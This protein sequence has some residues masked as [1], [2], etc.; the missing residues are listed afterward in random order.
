MDPEDDAAAVPDDRPAVPEITRRRLTPYLTGDRGY[1][2]SWLPTLLVV[3]VAG[4]L[5]TVGL[6]TPKGKI[7]DETYYATEAH[8]L[9]TYG[10]EWNFDE[11]KAAYVVHPPLGKWLI[12]VGE[13][14]FGYDEFGWRIAAAAAG[15]LSVLLLV[16]VARR[17]LRST[18]LGCLAGLLLALDGFHLVL[19]RS[20]LLDIFLGLFLL[21]AFAALV[22]DRDA[23][24]ARWL[25]ALERGA[26]RPEPAVRAWLLLAAGLLG[27]ATAVKWSGLFFAPAFA[28]LV[29]WWD[30]GARRSAG[31]DRPWR[32]AL[33]RDGLVWLPWCVA[34]VAGVYLLAWS[35]WL[36]TDDGY[37]R[38][39]LAQQGRPEPPLWGALQNLWHYHSEAL[40]FHSGLTSHHTYQSWPWQWLLL[41]RPVA[42]YWSGDAACGA[43]NCA[44][45]V[46]LLGTP[47][48]WWAFLP[49]LA[50]TTWLGVARRD[51]RA[52]AILV[53][54]AAGML[55]WF[56]YAVQG[57]TMFAFYALPAEPFLVLAL[58]YALGAWVGPR[59]A[60]APGTRRAVA[61]GAVA[62]YTLLV[63]ACF[64]WYY[65]LY[66]GTSIPYDDWQL[67][68][69]LGN[70]WI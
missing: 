59:P 49:A 56:Y 23:R 35:G 10:V 20:A 40:R 17:M 62:A 6:A 15:T 41:G 31:Q 43:S 51:W 8:G 32:R 19:S 54:V 66:V 29:V 4:L 28:L 9:L 39:W 30:A 57:R 64:A 16:R 2:W 52:G 69:L 11:N 68:M 27:A 26:D 65:P 58:C 61:I 42:F 13:R 37:F 48:L 24:R 21:A 45:E 38:H 34:A 50:A 3:L 1:A 44:A 14:L 53:G 7:F 60:G 67:R 55:P 5:R 33:V 36:L 70:R 22:R 25:A 12:A 63:A 18:V 47:V 46:L